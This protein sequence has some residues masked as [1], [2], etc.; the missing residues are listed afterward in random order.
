MAG[1]G[2]DSFPIIGEE[3]CAAFPELK[4]PTIDTL[5]FSVNPSI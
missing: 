3:K 5:L 4:M 1:Q 2:P